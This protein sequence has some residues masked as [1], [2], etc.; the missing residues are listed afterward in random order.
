MELLT[1]SKVTLFGN[2]KFIWNWF[3]VDCVRDGVVAGEGKKSLLLALVLV[4]SILP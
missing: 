3:N 2:I 1:Y 4:A